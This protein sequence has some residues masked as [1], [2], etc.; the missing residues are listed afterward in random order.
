M[1]TSAIYLV[2]ISTVSRWFDEKRGLALGIATSG[3]GVG[4]L[5]IA[6][7]ATYLISAFDWRMAYIVIGIM[8]WLFVIP[9]SG[10]LKRDPRE[11]GAVP[12][13]IESGTAGKQLRYPKNNKNSLHITDL[14]LSQA[15]RTRSLWLLMSIYFLF[16]SSHF[17]V[18]THVVPHAI[19]IGFS[20]GEGATIISLIGGSSILGRVI[21]GSASDR[22]G[23]RLTFTICAL[24]E[25]VAVLGLLWS[26]EL[27]VFYLLAVLYGFGFGGWPPILGSIVGDTF[28][29]KNLGAILGI[30]EVG[31]NVGAATGT[32]VGGLIFDISQSY[33]MAFLLTAI[34]L[35]IG[36]LLLISVGRET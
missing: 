35:F 34:S 36:A 32:A 28:G 21:M 20:A 25:C 9:L 2:T 8:V 18:T 24:A 27:R 10:L 26:N 15:F 29:L 30:T 7:F 4:P 17:L 14:S 13:D 19:D 16:S 6:P 12:E 5:V 22:M 3:S 33:F 31:F 11:I 23:K 1:G